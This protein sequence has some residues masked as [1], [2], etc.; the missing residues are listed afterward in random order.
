MAEV[1]RG[2]ISFKWR[3]FLISAHLLCC[4]VIR[5]H[6]YAARSVL[7]ALFSNKAVCMDTRRLGVC[8][9]LHLDASMTHIV[10]HLN[11][12]TNRISLPFISNTMQPFNYFRTHV[13]L[14]IIWEITGHYRSFWYMCVQ[15]VTLTVGYVRLFLSL[16]APGRPPWDGPSHS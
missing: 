15:L 9:E 10:K 11:R 8:H 13:H 3:I 7:V 2:V 14:R 12:E 5:T 1:L 4:E 16:D 6:V